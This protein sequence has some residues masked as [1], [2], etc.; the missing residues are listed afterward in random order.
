MPLVLLHTFVYCFFEIKHIWHILS[1]KKNVLRSILFLRNYCTIL[2]LPI[3][4]EIIDGFWCSRCLNDGIDLLYMIR[5]LASGATNS[6]VVKIGTKDPATYYEVYRI[7]NNR[8]ILIFKVSKQEYWSP[9]MIGSFESDTNAFIVAKNRTKDLSTSCSVYR[10]W[11]NGW[12]STFK[13]SKRL[14]RSPLHDRI[15]CKWRQCLLGGQK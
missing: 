4:S 7:W 8:R 9:N 3:S 13:V 1:Y 14:Y 6:L 11:N 15:I 2:A 10:I 5:S 12:I